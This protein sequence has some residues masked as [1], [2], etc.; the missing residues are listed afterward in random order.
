M[1]IKMPYEKHTITILSAKEE[2]GHHLGISLEIW[3]L[4]ESQ[5]CEEICKDSTLI[6]VEAEV[7][8][9]RE[10]ILQKICQNEELRGM[11]MRIMIRMN[12]TWFHRLQLQIL[13]QILQ[14]N[15]LVEIFDLTIM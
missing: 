13:Q 1:R 7:Q 6:E 3:S 15:L 4:Q 5:I 14:Q 9:E 8:E 11:L 12:E 2:E 10:A